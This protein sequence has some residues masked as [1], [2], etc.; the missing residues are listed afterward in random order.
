[1]TRTPQ[2]KSTRQHIRLWFEWY[3]ICLRDPSLKG[4]LRKS[5]KFYEP[6][7]DVAEVPFDEWWKTHKDLFGETKVTEISKVSKH[8][9]VLNLSV[10][11]NQPISRV[12]KEVRE[13]VEKKQNERLAE[14][15]L[16]DKKTKSK[17]PTYGL[18]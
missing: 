10:P 13:L 4:N 16:S 9:N 15:G 2:I 5:K 12:M 6:W 7:G 17:V 14:I 3:K 8:S 18:Y 11:L 1:M